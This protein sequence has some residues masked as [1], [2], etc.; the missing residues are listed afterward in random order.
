MRFILWCRAPSSLGFLGRLLALDVILSLTAREH[1]TG[2][3]TKTHCRQA[4]RPTRRRRGG[5]SSVEQTVALTPKVNQMQRFQSFPFSFYFLSR[6]L[7]PATDLSAEHSCAPSGCAFFLIC[8]VFF[9]NISHLY[10]FK[11]S[12]HPCKVY[13]AQRENQI[14]GYLGEH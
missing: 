13:L 2:T 6:P 3:E 9:L 4:Q 12:L 14:R 10:Q 11:P 1:I 5:L 8:F 7:I